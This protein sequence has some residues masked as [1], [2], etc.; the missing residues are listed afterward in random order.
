MFDTLRASITL[1]VHVADND[2]AR[3]AGERRLDQLQERLAA[4]LL[5]SRAPVNGP[6]EELPFVST[7]GEAAFKAAVQR[8]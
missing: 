3:A 5:A 7:K 1:V 4:P 2:T 8:I 6:A